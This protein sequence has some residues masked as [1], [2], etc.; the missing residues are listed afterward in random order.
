MADK[1]TWCDMADGL[2]KAMD[3]LQPA[4]EK[5][6]IKM[7]DV[8]DTRSSYVNKDGNATVM[9]KCQLLIPIKNAGRID[10]TK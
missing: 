4:L 7:C 8:S 9:I 3:I 5:A 1:D 6:N 10:P 2:K